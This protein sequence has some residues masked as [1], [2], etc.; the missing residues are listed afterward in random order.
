MDTNELEDLPKVRGSMDIGVDTS[1]LVQTV[2]GLT[3]SPGP[4]KDLAGRKREE[5][6]AAAGYIKGKG[7]EIWGWGG[8]NGSGLRILGLGSGSR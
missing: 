8:G 7:E 2:K 3:L 5:I 6:E 1:A 4:R